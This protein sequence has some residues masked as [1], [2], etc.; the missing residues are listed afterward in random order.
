MSSAGLFGPPVIGAILILMSK[1]K[2][3]TKIILY[4]LSVAMLLSVIVWARIT[5]G[6]IV[7]TLLSI[8]LFVIAKKGNE[9]LQ[10]L[11]VQFLGV[12]ACIDTY[13]QIRYLYTESV[14]INGQVL[15]SDTGKMAE[16]LGFNYAFWGT[17]ILALSFSLLIYSLYIRHRQKMV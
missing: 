9:T 4:V 11:V 2:K 1:R 3:T 5:V 10:Q 8:I 7:I 17:L 13:K 12:T 6:I 16:Y 14:T 15:L